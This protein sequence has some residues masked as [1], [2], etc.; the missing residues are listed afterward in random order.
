MHEKRTL[1]QVEINHIFHKLTNRA[2]A[3]VN[4]KEQTT[5]IVSS[6]EQ[7]LNRGEEFERVR[8]KDFKGD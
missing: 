6:K 3:S 8:A 4:N 2:K 5:N 1:P 7:Q